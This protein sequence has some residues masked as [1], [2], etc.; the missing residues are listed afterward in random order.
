MAKN[1]NDRDIS[2]K[3]IVVSENEEWLQRPI[4]QKFCD[5][6]FLRIVLFYVLHSPCKKSSYSRVNLEDYGWK[7]PWHKE[8]FKE[9]I[10]GK[11]NFNEKSFRFTSAHKDFKTLWIETE[12]PDN[13]YDE[14]SEEFAVFS[15][16]GESNPHLDMLHHIRNSLA[17][18]RFTVKKHNKEFY[19]FMEDVRE[20]Y[21]QLAVNARIVLKKKTLLN[22]IDIF[23]CK[24]EEAKKLCQD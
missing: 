21:N 17:H 15:H 4:S 2:N 6:D 18:G 16:A 19:I 8:K 3:Y 13:F 23:E 1:Q 20:V 10:D 7:N 5:E 12:K 14:I 11:A 9:I 24:S 22:W